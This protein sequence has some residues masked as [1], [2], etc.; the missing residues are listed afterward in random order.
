MAF[1]M[2]LYS[3]IT[4]T[5]YLTPLLTTYLSY[6]QPAYIVLYWLFF[7]VY[8]G[9]LIANHRSITSFELVVLYLLLVPFYLAIPASILWGQSMLYGIAASREWFLVVAPIAIFYMFKIKWVTLKEI[10]DAMLGLGWLYLSIFTAVAILGNPHQYMGT[11]PPVYVSCNL[12]KGACTY[13]LDFIAILFACIYYYIKFLKKNDWR[14][15]IA[16]L[17]FLSYLAFEDKKRALLLAL[18]LTLF[19]IFLTQL[20]WKKI[21]LYSVAII[22]FLVTAISTIYIIAPNVIQNYITMYSNVLTVLEGQ[23]A[24]ESSADVRIYETIEAITIIQTNP[25]SLLIGNGRISDHYNNGQYGNFAHFYPSDIDI[26]G[27]VFQYGIVGYIM[28]QME[29]VYIFYLWW[30]IKKNKNN[31]YLKATF[32]LLICFFLNGGSMDC[33]TAGIASTPLF[34]CLIYCFVYLEK[35]ESK[36]YEVP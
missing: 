8:I 4:Q 32:F 18:A 2:I 15:A 5:L 9:D 17:C 27:A 3:T 10:Y 1:L 19:F 12:A 33:F 21:V 36:G 34:I 23:K 31:L 28:V 16:F 24:N 22:F 25:I 29:Y 13:R 30:R 20:P 26:I 14:S 6:I 35:H 11:H 7:L